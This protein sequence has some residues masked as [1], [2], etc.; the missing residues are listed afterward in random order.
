MRINLSYII[1]H[2]LSIII[3]LVQKKEP[4]L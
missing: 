2:I 4:T 3:N 1:I